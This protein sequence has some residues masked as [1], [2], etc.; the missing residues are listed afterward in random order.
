MISRKLLGGDGK[1][2]YTYCRLEI[3]KIK[4]NLVLTVYADRL[5]NRARFV[6]EEKYEFEDCVVEDKMTYYLNILFVSSIDRVLACKHFR[7][8]RKTTRW[9]REKRRKPTRYNIRVPR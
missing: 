8:T 3:I 5:I 1:Y 2:T 4:T 9:S 6:G 7:R